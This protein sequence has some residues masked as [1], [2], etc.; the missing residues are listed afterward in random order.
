MG[1]LY[2]QLVTPEEDDLFLKQNGLSVSNFKDGSLF[3]QILKKQ[4]IS[5]QKYKHLIECVLDAIFIADAESGIIIEANRRAVELLGISIEQII[6]MHQSQLHPTEKGEKYKQ[7]FQEHIQEKMTHLAEDIYVQHKNG[8]QI[9]VQINATVTQLGKRKVIYGI[10][11]NLTEQ[12]KI[13][14]ELAEREK[15]YREMCDHVQVALYRTRISDGKLLE[16]NNALATL[17]GYENKEQCL[18]D[19][20]SVTHYVDSTQWTELMNRLNKEG[21]VQDFEI[22]F[23]RQDGTHAWVEITA[24]LHLKEGYIEGA[25]VD[26][27]ASKILTKT[28]KKILLLIMQGKSNKGIAKNLNR[29]VRTIEDHRANIMRKLHARNLVELVQKSQSLKS[30]PKKQ[31]IF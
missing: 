27:T 23:V 7:L 24:K 1:G 21:Y 29:S 31:K 2:E 25:Q 6:G 11:Q 14:R 26:I 5:E 4:Q 9:P 17:L 19:Y 15:K 12:K 13:E 16:C 10:F 8:Q 30:H 3:E 18:S 28:E 20:Y 22:E